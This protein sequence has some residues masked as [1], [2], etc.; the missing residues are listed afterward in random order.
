MTVIS[1][2][3]LRRTFISR[4]K[5]QERAYNNIGIYYTPR[6]YK[7]LVKDKEDL[8]RRLDKI[9]HILVDNID[10][11]LENNYKIKFIELEELHLKQNFVYVRLKS[12]NTIHKICNFHLTSLNVRHITLDHTTSFYDLIDTNKHKLPALIELTKEI[13]KGKHLKKEEMRNE[14]PRIVSYYNMENIISI[15]NEVS[16]LAT[17]TTL[18]LLPSFK[19]F[20]KGKKSDIITL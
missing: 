7:K 9:Y 17:Q 10:I 18:R 6:L 12:D 1:E 19:N 20:S 2:T 13:K 4:L 16:L 8:N 15:L 11:D 5:T 3:Q 14:Y